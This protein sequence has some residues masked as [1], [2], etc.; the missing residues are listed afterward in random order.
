MLI[1]QIE[2]HEIA[3]PFVELRRTFKI[4]EQERQAQDF[5]A[6]IGAKRIRPID[7]AE[8]LIGEEPLR[9]ENGLAPL[10][11]IVQ[12]LVRHPDG[13]QHATIGAVFES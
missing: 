2:S 11:E 13:R 8:G 7:I 3:D 1:D 4:A 10:Q 9:G 5:E 6:L 12:R